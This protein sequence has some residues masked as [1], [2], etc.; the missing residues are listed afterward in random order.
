[1]K[2][3]SAFPRTPDGQTLYWNFQKINH[4][5][6]LAAA[7]L[8]IERSNDYR[9]LSSLSAWSVKE[10]LKYP[11]TST[12][13]NNNVLLAMPQLNA[14][15]GAD[16]H[17]DIIFP[18]F[19]PPLIPFSPIILTF[20][21]LP[22]SPPLTLFNI[23]INICSIELKWDGKITKILYDNEMRWIRITVWN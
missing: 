21:A 16:C 19:L 10:V 22:P 7:L 12:M 1:M 2:P 17:N 11:I 9:V 20:P 8:M 18:Y 5:G 6:L 15:C 3:C 4:V 13:A 14:K 23:N